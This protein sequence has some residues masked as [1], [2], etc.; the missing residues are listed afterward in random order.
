MLAVWACTRRAHKASASQ[1]SRR[2]AALLRG[3]PPTEMTGPAAK[4]GRNAARVAA[5]GVAEAAFAAPL[6]LAP[7]A[8]PQAM[9][10]V[11]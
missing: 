11:D 4:L 7:A 2:E 6:A 1:P 3:D 5:Y 10:P 8:A 9:L